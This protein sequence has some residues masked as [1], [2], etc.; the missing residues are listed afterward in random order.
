MWSLAVEGFG[1]EGLEQGDELRERVRV[2]P[3]ATKSVNMGTRVWCVARASRAAPVVRV[4]CC[5]MYS[6]CRACRV[7]GVR[8]FGNQILVLGILDEDRRTA[9]RGCAAQV[10]PYK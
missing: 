4:A 1:H 3:A 2:V 9:S 10:V 6:V 8:G 5:A 7:A